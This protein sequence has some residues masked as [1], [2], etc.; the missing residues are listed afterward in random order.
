[1][2]RVNVHKCS[3]NFSLS[4]YLFYVYKCN[5]NIFEMV[6]MDCGKCYEK[7]EGYLTFGDGHVSLFFWCMKYNKLCSEAINECEL[8]DG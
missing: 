8:K 6:R 2:D 5:I 1:M 7:E 3:W 4:I